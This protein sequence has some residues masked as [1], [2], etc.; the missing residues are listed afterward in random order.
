[1][2][3]PSFEKAHSEGALGLRAI[4]QVVDRLENGLALGE[5]RFALDVL[6]ARARRQQ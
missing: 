2:N 1:M 4:R 5:S 3:E 6:R